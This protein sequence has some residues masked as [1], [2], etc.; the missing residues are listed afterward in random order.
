[1]AKHLDSLQIKNF[2]MLEDF[3]VERLGQ[4]NLIVGKNNSGKSTALEALRLYAG[5][6]DESLLKDLATFHGEPYQVVRKEYNKLTILPFQSFF[7]GRELVHNKKIEIGCQNKGVLEIAYNGEFFYPDELKNNYPDVGAAEVQSFLCDYLQVTRSIDD[8]GAA[9]I[10]FMSNEWAI[11]V[12]DQNVLQHS[13][14]KSRIESILNL[15][16]V[17][18]QLAQLLD[19]ATRWDLIVFTDF[20]SIITQALQIIEPKIQGLAFVQDASKNTGER[21][22]IVRLKGQSQPVPLK[23]LG[24]GMQRILQIVLNIYSAKDGLLLIDEFENG[25]HYSV[26]EKVWGLMFEMAQ[27]LNIQVFATTHSRDCIEAFSKVAND[28]VDV[29]GLLFRMGRSAKA[30]DEGKIIATIFDEARLDR[31][32]QSDMEIR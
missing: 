1:M 32:T 25:L 6:T 13:L 24:D 27:R 26:Q 8:S 5:R 11:N 29:E 17:P 15:S 18:T 12:L 16:F 31:M 20:E 9:N 14:P 30:S 28:R 23:S 10:V 7:S 19:L 3:T 2:R 22:A 4:V 21:T